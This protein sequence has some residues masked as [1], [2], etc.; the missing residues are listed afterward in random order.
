MQ[1]WIASEMIETEP[2]ML[3]IVNFPMTRKVLEH[4]DKSAIRDFIL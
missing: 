1:E 3:P 2:T 4:T